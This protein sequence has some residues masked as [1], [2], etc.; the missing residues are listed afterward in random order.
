LQ[1]LLSPGKQ[2]VL[3]ITGRPGHTY[4]VQATQNLTNWNVIGIVTLDL[5]ASFDF[6]VDNAT[7]QPSGFYR[8]REIL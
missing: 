5:G 1:L 2:V 6:I 3:R 7:S 4:E 8:L